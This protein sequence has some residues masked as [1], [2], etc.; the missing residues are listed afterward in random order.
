MV[1]TLLGEMFYRFGTFPL[2]DDE[3]LRAK[4]RMRRTLTLWLAIAS[5]QIIAIGIWWL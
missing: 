4:R 1:V 5:A 3:Y 2:G